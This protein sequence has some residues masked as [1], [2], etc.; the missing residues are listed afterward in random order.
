[1]S[2][3]IRGWKVRGNPWGALK[4]PGVGGRIIAQSGKRDRLVDP[5]L[6]GVTKS[7]G[8]GARLRDWAAND[9]QVRRPRPRARPKEKVMECVF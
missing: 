8:Y 5:P 2:G 9:A 3:L 6:A 1:M 4:K 7:R